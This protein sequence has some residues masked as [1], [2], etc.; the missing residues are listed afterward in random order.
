MGNRL[1]HVVAHIW[2]SGRQVV[3]LVQLRDGSGEVY[4][5]IGYGRGHNEHT[6]LA[7]I[8]HWG[9]SFPKDFGDW[10]FNGL[11]L[12]TATREN[13]ASGITQKSLT[14]CPVPFALSTFALE[15]PTY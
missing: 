6:D 10:I 14:E 9:A 8:C 7:M 15:D 13:K 2:F 4:Y 12:E 5:L 3:G 11:E 1:N